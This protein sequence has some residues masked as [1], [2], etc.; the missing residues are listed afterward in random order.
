MDTLKRS[1]QASARGTRT[2]RR[3]LRTRP[4]RS[5]TACTVVIAGHAALTA[6]VTYSGA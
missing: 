5:S 2:R 1:G 3:P 6:L 4:W